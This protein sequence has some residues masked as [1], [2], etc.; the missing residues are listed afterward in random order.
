MQIRSFTVHGFAHFDEPI[1]MSPVDTVN[2]VYG[3]NQIGKSSFLQSIALYFALLG[4][5]E[6][7]TRT[8]PQNMEWSDGDLAP[9]QHT[10]FHWHSAR[11][12]RYDVTWEI[13]T[14]D[15]DKYGL[16]PELPCEKV[17]TVLEFGLINRALEL[18][19]ASWALNDQDVAAMDRARDGQQVTFGQ[20]L[21][22]LL[23]DARPFQQENPIMPCRLIGA[24]AE[25]FPQTLRDALFDARQSLDPDTRR[26]WALFAELSPVFTQELGPG[27]WETTFDRKTGQADV[28]WIHEASV[29]PL[30]RVGTGVQ[31]LAGLVAQL[32]LAFEPG[33]LLEEPEWKLSPDFQRRLL[34]VIRKVVQAGVGPRQLFLSTHSPTLAAHKSGF[35]ME[36][37][38]V[39]LRVV[40]RPWIAAGEAVATD[41][42][43]DP[44]EADL[45]SL[46]GLVEDL[47]ELD[48]S[49]IL[50]A[51]TPSGTAGGGRPGP[52]R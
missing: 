7:V 44:P 52:Q 51:E 46:I 43:E 4:S 13:S 27:G 50:R 45:G 42:D 47:A 39:G 33:L 9:F 49:D 5:G 28:L 6:S 23:A 15:L 29:T 18:R 24:N 31:R 3:P 25:P 1:T 10:A 40:Q 8:Q 48:E 20:Q 37:S 22:R 26:R 35:E 38:E 16:F 14:R 17:R 12:I 11:P 2:A 21:R 36:R 32:V 30:A 19:I 34:G 41:A